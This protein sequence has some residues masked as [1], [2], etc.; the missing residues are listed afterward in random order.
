M[1]GWVA[2]SGGDDLVE[3]GGGGVGVDGVVDEVGEKLAGV[4]SSTTWG[5]L[6][7]LPVVMSNW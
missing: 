4:N 3:A 6:M 7:V 1:K 5:I 2:A